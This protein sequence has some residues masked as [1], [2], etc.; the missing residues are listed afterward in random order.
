[1]N[2]I[3]KQKRELRFC[4]PSLRP[5]FYKIKKKYNSAELNRN[6]KYTHFGILP[7]KS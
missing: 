3:K 6:K 1:M 2:K 4:K 5:L 7:K